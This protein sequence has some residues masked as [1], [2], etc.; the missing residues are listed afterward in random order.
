M[1]E[2]LPPTARRAAGGR[3]WAGQG[4]QPVLVP[5]SQAVSW[6]T[7]V[8]DQTMDLLNN[9]QTYPYFLPEILTT[10]SNPSKG[11][12]GRTTHPRKTLPKN[13]RKPWK[14]ILSRAFGQ[15]G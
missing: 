11:R 3:A 6:D 15:A 7:L 12:G 13:W 5:V 8:G 10:P 2:R 14:K 1:L 4:Q 9:P